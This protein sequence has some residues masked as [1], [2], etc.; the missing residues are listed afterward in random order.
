[1]RFAGCGSPRMPPMTCGTT[2]A[3]RCCARATSA[4]RGKPEPWRCCRSH[5]TAAWAF[6]SSPV[7]SRRRPRW[8][9]S[10]RRSTRSWAITCRRTALWRSPRGRDGQRLSP[11]S[12]RSTVAEAAARGEGMGLSI[13]DY[14]SAVLHNGLG[15]YQEALRAAEQG[16]GYHDELGFS[17][18]S[19][20][21]LVE[22][23]ARSGHPDS[24]A[25]AFELLT[26]TTERQRY[27]LGPGNRIPISRTGE[28]GRSGRGLLR[29]GSRAAR[30]DS[31][32]RR[33]RPRSVALRRVAAAGEPPS[34]SPQPPEVGVRPAH[35]DGRGG[36]RRTSPSRTGRHRRDAH[37]GDPSRLGRDFTAQEAQIA[38]LAAEGRTNP[39][40]GAELF[41]SPRTVEWHLHKVFAKLGIGSR[42]ELSDALLNT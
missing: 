32:A 16:A 4:L 8:S 3:G 38:R 10:S 5:S 42:R 41:L 7:S 1:M 23:A 18:W 2:R 13:V 37:A 30:P 39:E 17:T 25:D 33:A 29:R 31:D 36:L 11:V 14:S 20:V 9:T 28:P 26:R 22:A 34:R 21:E 12:L 40:I 35:R 15:N 6:T 24:A 19:L 27:R